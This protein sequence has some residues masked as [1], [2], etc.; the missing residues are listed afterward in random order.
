MRNRLAEGNLP[1]D[2]YLPKPFCDVVDQRVA[3]LDKRL[4]ST[5]LLMFNGGNDKLV[6]AE[7]NEALVAKLDQKRRGGDWDYIVVPNV[8]H[9]WCD[10]MVDKSVAWVNK[11]M[12]Q[13]DGFISSKL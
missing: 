13:G 4:A 6:K 12:I 5:H 11:W 2:T 3:N 1:A 10:E 8:G 9:A 7:F